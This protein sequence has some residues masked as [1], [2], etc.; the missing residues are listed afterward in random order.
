MSAERDNVTHVENQWIFEA[1]SINTIVNDNHGTIYTYDSAMNKDEN[2]IFPIE[3][4]FRKEKGGIGS[5]NQFWLLLIA[6]SARGVKFDSIPDFINKT[7][8][9]WE[10]IPF[11][12]EECLASTQ[13]LM[14]GQGWSCINNQQDMLEFIK[15]FRSQGAKRETE[16][17]IANRLFVALK[18]NPWCKS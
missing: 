10:N 2:S 5:R 1:G 11:D 16:I 4:I 6:A 13:N 7:F 15:T 18:E 17:K 8:D 9:T 3:D 14:K 12:K